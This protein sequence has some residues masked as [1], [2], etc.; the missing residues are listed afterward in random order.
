MTN[1]L[2][3]VANSLD[4]EDSLLTDDYF[5]LIQNKLDFKTLYNA[6]G[7]KYITTLLYLIRVH[8]I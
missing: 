4:I 6:R 5:Q 2:I 7:P 8:E 1:F 3:Q